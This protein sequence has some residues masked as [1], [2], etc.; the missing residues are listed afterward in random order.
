[1]VSGTRKL[2]RVLMDSTTWG[3]ARTCPN[4]NR[5]FKNSSA[6]L[7]HMNHRYSSCHLWFSKDPQQPPPRM[8]HSPDTHAKSPSHYFPN[9]GHVFDSGPGFLGWFYNDGNANARSNN[10]YHPFLSKGE[11][12]VARFL[13][14]S[15]LSMKLINEFLSLNLVSP[16]PDVYWYRTQLFP[17]Y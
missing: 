3:R 14:C 12:E 10:L 11:W 2:P 8:E 5:V 16:S 6:V 15:G 17:D 1:M 4:C 9:A 7:K 13:S